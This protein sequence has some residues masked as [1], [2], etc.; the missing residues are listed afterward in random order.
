ML[1]FLLDT[2]VLSEP[3]A[4]Q[5]NK[6]VLKNLLSHQGECATAAPV[7]HELRYGAR[8]LEPS[9]R[10]VALERYIEGVVLRVYPVLP[11]NTAAAEWHAEQRAR[12]QKLGK[13]APFVDGLIAAITK[14]NDLVLVT[15]NVKDFRRFTGLTVEDWRAP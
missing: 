7:I 8:L 13:P 12:L 2:N 14:V 1:R 5:G 4:R 9:H 10:R 3:V 6:R 11:Y 15:A